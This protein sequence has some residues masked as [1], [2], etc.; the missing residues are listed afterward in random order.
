MAL[1]RPNKGILFLLSA[2][3]LVV[4]MFAA[5][6]WTTQ[7]SARQIAS[8]QVEQ[9]Q[10]LSYLD[11]V[12]YPDDFFSAEEQAAWN[13]YRVGETFYGSNNVTESLAKDV[14]IM[15]AELGEEGIDEITQAAAVDAVLTSYIAKDQPFFR[16]GLTD[17]KTVDQVTNPNAMREYVNA[18]ARLES[19]FVT[20]IQNLVTEVQAGTADVNVLGLRH[21]QFAVELGEITVPS[22]IALMHIDRMN[23]YDATGEAYLELRTA[24]ANDPAKALLISTRLSTLEEALAANRDSLYNYIVSQNLVFR[25][26]EPGY[27][28]TNNSNQ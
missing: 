28:I 13:N 25:S 11:E 7:R 12:V 19:A 18:S 8:M 1:R 9:Q 20:D 15:S 27:L 17:V 23:I 22:L 2:C 26:D 10:N 3:V 14:F 6:R 4:L 21:K 24:T 16:Y 5:V